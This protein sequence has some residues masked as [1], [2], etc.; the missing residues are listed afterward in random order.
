[1]HDWTLLTVDVDWKSGLL[2]LA[3]RSRAGVHEIVG[4]GLKHLDVTRSL[5]W[6]PAIS[7]NDVT[8]PQKRDDGTV[9]LKLDMQSG[10]TIEFVAASIDMPDY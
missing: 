6:G 10:D 4:H 8:G 9:S 7:I 3:V 5:D 1:M 2:R